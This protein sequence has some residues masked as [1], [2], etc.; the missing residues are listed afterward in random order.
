MPL[1]TQSPRHWPA[2]HGAHSSFGTKF[3]ALEARADD[4]T[5]GWYLLGERE[6]VTLYANTTLGDRGMNIVSGTAVA[7]GHM[8]ELF[9]NGNV[10]Q[11]YVSNVAADVGFD[12]LTIDVPL[13]FAFTIAGATGWVGVRNAAV[14]GD[15]TD[16]PFTLIPPAGHIWDISRL[17]F[18]ILDQ[19]AMDSSLFG[20]I[21]ALTSGVVVRVYRSDTVYEHLAV[22]HHNAEFFYKNWY[23]SWG[24]NVESGYY[25]LVSDLLFGNEQNDGAL[26]RLDGTKGEYLEV[27]VA[28]D[29]TDLDLM[30]LYAHGYILED[31][32]PE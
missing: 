15:A 12:T 26:L 1:G 7:T 20:G 24:S 22:F 11:A 27:L 30:K 10:F 2:N 28:D 3:R 32:V 14:D 21:T 9:E 25:S 8:V 16:V 18:Y 5:L 13:P 31:S 6:A 17:H 29:L 23:S 4:R 19:T